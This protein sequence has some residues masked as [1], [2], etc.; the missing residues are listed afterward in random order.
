MSARCRRCAPGRPCARDTV[1]VG[2]G[3]LLVPDQIGQDSFLFCL[4][5]TAKCR[6]NQA[7]TG[8]E[9]R[10]V[11][12]LLAWPLV[13][14]HALVRFAP[15]QAAS[16]VAWHTLRDAVPVDAGSEVRTTE[17]HNPQAGAVAVT[18]K[19]CNDSPG[20]GP[21]MRGS[22]LPPTCRAAAA[23]RDDGRT[24]AERLCCAASRPASVV[25][26]GA[27]RAAAKTS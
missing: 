8:G 21:P 3:R 5:A 14:W 20:T 9:A 17:R 1:N 22:S 11:F 13:R 19:I 27:E 12:A 10:Q 18:A 6:A 16:T 23:C 25:A 4:H 26:A 2:L 24:A 15:S 7:W